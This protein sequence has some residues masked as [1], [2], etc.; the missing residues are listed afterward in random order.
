MF[1]VSLRQLRAPPLGREVWLAAL[2][3]KMATVIPDDVQSFKAAFEVF[4]HDKTGEISYVDFPNAVRAIGFNPT[5][6]Q[7]VEVLK[8]ANKGEKDK[9]NFDEFVDMLG[10]FNECRKEDAEESLR[11]AFK[12][13]D[14]DGN[15]YISPDEL[16]YVVCNSG[17]KLS[18]EE[19]EELIG[20]FDKN[21]DGQLSWE[22]FVEFF[23]C[24]REATEGNVTIPEESSQEEPQ[25]I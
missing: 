10:K 14:R 19:A 12:K 22:E 21:D 5:N 11:E 7:V 23:K 4:D 6:N 8:A 13:F 20:M 2:R 1:D 15:G 9:I 17:E 16:L 25:L 18:R 3:P 24:D